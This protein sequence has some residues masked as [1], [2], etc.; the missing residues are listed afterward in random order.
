MWHPMSWQFFEHFVLNFYMYP[1]TQNP[2]VVLFLR[3]DKN[4]HLWLEFPTATASHRRLLRKKLRIDPNPLS[5]ATPVCSSNTLKRNPQ[6]RASNLGH[7]GEKW[8]HGPLHHC[9]A[10]DT[11]ILCNLRFPHGPDRIPVFLHVTNN[12]HWH[13][14]LWSMQIGLTITSLW[15]NNYLDFRENKTFLALE[16]PWFQQLIWMR[17]RGCLGGGRKRG[18][19]RGRQE[20]RIQ[21]DTSQERGVN[22]TSWYK[23]FSLLL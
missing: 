14:S 12:S 22:C 2:S 6:R 18:R 20:G 3:R 11:L 7:S 17:R 21:F 15:T 1:K 19:G 8:Q 16:W 5:T 10:Y 13:A 23:T 4:I 9:V